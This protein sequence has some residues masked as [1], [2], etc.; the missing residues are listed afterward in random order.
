MNHLKI[1]ARAKIN[2][3]LEVIGKRADGYHM[4][5]MVMQTIDIKDNIRIQKNNINKIIVE[6]D[7]LTVPNG[8]KNIA[9]TAVELFNEEICSNQGYDIFINKN[10]PQEAGM[11]GGS[12]DAA[13]ILVG[14]NQMN[15]NPINQKRLLEIGL[16]LGADVPFC[17]LG[18]TKLAQGVGEEFTEIKDLNLKL[19]IVKPGEGISTQKAF[20]KLNINNIKSNPDNNRLIEAINTKN[21]PEIYK[22]MDNALY[23]VGL[24]FAPEMELIIDELTNKFSSPK[25]MMTGSG[26]T[27]FAIFE[28]DK[29]IE[30][31]FKYFSKKYKDVFITKT[32]KEPILWEERM[33]IGILFGGK[34]AEHEVSCISACSIFKNIDREKYEP[35][36]IGV[37]RKGKFRYYD[38]DTKHLLDATWE[39][40]VSD[41]EVEI[42]GNNKAPGIYGKNLEVQLDCI[43]PVLH[44]P[45]GE[46]G[47]LQGILE[48]SKLPYVG[49]NVLSSSM[50]MDKA[51]TKEILKSENI[52]Q[53]RHIV[54]RK[55]F[56]RTKIL[57]KLNDFSYPLFVKPSNM[58]SSVG[59]TKVNTPNEVEKAVE[60]ALEYDHKIIIEEGIN[61]RE[62][63]VAVIGNRDG[64]LVSTPGEIVV[65]DDFYDYETKYIKATSKL[66]IPA[67][68][69]EESIKQIKEL[70]AKAFELLECSGISRIDFFVDRESG[71]IILNEI[72]TMPG[73]TKI[74]MYPKLLEYDGIGYKELITKLIELAFERR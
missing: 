59:I 64:L 67:D 48:Y 51:I 66:M 25:A 15:K 29:D 41:S 3:S 44:G 55:G 69:P 16:K 45:F 19:L 11:G 13:G 53:A 39:N 28:N 58:G 9:Y 57:E 18:G 17:I 40:Y 73:F 54:W 63:E 36:L 14:L 62:I 38:S 74:S 56:D 6:T 12:A 50:C 60:K 31:A 10:I 70:A 5:S 1:A 2:L 27:I 30:S 35:Y 43:F 72:N 68:L 7:S 33:K 22:S 20:K 4:L 61:A 37:T 42:L 8:E 65:N 34:S 24:E 26:S 46:D 32:V 21:M 71:R 23:E 49:C 47:R 52:S